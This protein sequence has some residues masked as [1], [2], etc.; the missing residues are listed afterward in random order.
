MLGNK[1]PSLVR[2]E[3]NIR[4]NRKFV[5]FCCLSSQWDTAGQERFQT[6]PSSYYRAGDGIMIVYDVTKMESFNNV[7]Q[8]L[9]EIAKNAENN[10]VCKLLVGN[11]C[12]LV[13]NKVV[14]TQT[15]KVLII[16]LVEFMHFLTYTIGY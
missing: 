16:L 11:K 1:L 3:I 5:F 10:N 7:K 9:N 4:S 2:V 13:H 15:A 12:D 8:W 6:L 14:D